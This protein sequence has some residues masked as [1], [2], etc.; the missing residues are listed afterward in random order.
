MSVKVCNEF[1]KLQQTGEFLVRWIKL[2]WFLIRPL[3]GALEFEDPEAPDNIDLIN[4]M[5]LGLHPTYKNFD[6][7]AQLMQSGGTDPSS[8]DF[9][10]ISQALFEYLRALNLTQESFASPNGD[11]TVDSFDCASSF[12]GPMGPFGDD[13]ELGSLATSAAAR[14]CFN[15]EALV[16][17]QLKRQK[18]EKLNYLLMHR[19]D[20]RWLRSMRTNCCIP[21]AILAFI[22]LVL[23]NLSSNWIRFDSNCLFY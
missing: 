12:A 10:K 16:A 1:L 21:F 7:I 2:V 8:L 19:W 18:E 17:Q 3:K 23:T 6:A 5:D 13:C 14:R 22:F 20:P 11:P 15:K 4:N 9:D